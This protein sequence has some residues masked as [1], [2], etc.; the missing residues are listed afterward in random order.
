MCSWSGA[1]RKHRP[2][3]HRFMENEQLKVS[4]KTRGLNFIERCS[5]CSVC[6]AARHRLM[7]PEGSGRTGVVSQ[8]TVG[9]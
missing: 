4:T 2:R 7:M 9:V 1:H 5:A 8:R 6:T 3:E